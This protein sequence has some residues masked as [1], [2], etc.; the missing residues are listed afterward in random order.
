M[1]IIL[2]KRYIY[3]LL[4]FLCIGV[5][6]FDIY[7]LTIAIWTITAIVTR[8]KAYSLNFLKIVICIVIILFIAFIGSLF[9]D[10]KTYYVIRDIAYMTKPILGL[11]IGYQLCKPNFK[12]IFQTIVYTGF[13]IASIHLF[14]LAFSV[15][16]HNVRTL[17]ELRYVGGYFSDFEVY[18]LL[19]LV[20]HKSFE[21]NFTA[22]RFWLLTLILA[23]SSIMYLART[24]FIQ[25][26]ILFVG[27]KG[28]FKINR[29]SIMVVSSIITLT[30]IGY[31]TILYMNPKRNGPG[32]EA[33]LY[34]I[35]IAPQEAF[36]M[37]IDRENWRDFNDN[38]R[39]YENIST[40]KQVTS[41]GSSTIIFGESIGSK[42]DLKQKLWLGDLELRY[43]SILH[44]GFM[45]VFL[46]SG[47]LGIFIYLYSIFL[48]FK[49]KNSQFFINQNI[50]L[51]LIGTGV[52]LIFSNWVF[53]GIYNKSDNKAILIG[54][55]YC[56]K[57]LVIKKNQAVSSVNNEL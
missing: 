55:L 11:L 37:K 54:L 50:N 24:N 12:H 49:Q 48:L 38:Y 28:Y 57:E 5:T 43:I 30:L 18:A 9:K 33:L 42:V 13:I 20:F 10:Y 15:I 41:K 32:I 56:Y 53:M 16:F 21:L 4:F 14:I 36:K 31:F 51:L 2:S 17:N 52:F 7:E 22:K 1:K 27:M 19:I 47:L 26:I 46:K 6:Y 34:K 45:T 8:Q 3:Q 44:N 25:F 35:K 39:A 23:L 40:V 29:A